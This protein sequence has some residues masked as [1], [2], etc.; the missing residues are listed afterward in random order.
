MRT[1][2]SRWRL[3]FLLLLAVGS[4]HAQTTFGFTGQVQTYTIPAAAGGIS[5]Q[6]SGAGGGGGGSDAS[7]NGFTGA[8][9]AGGKGASA[10]AT[11]IGPPGTVVKVYVG[12]GGGRGFTS[13]FGQSC[14]TSAGGGG[15]GSG[16]GGFAGGTG[17]PAGCSGYSG[18]GGGGGAAS[19]V[20]TA[21]DVALLVAGSGGGGQGGSWE[22][23]PNT[24]ANSS[25]QGLLANASV[26]S[27]GLAPNATD[28]GG[29]GG[30]GGGCAGGRGGDGHLDKSGNANSNPAGPG[31]SCPNTDLV[32]NFSVLAGGGGAGGA[33][34]PGDPSTAAN[35][36]QPGSN[37]SVVITPLY[38]TLG[39]VKSQPSPALAMGSNSVYTLTVSNSASVPANTARVLD[40]LPANLGYAG[41]SGTGWTCSSAANAAGTLVTC[42]FSGTI[43]P[44]GSTSLQVSVIPTNNLAVTNYASVD[45]A[46][47]TAPPN[48]ASCT[49]PNMPSAGCAA[50]VRSATATQ[51]G[52]SVYL[53]A[54]HNS[55]LDGGES[56]TG[57]ASLYVK[58]IPASGGTCTGPALTAA[59][60][61]AATG[62]YNLGN[63]AQGSYC[64]VLDANTN[65]SDITPAVPPGFIPTQN[66]S[67]VIRLV[68]GGAPP[69]PQNFGLYAGA[70]LSGSV[71]GDT[72]TGA[73]NANNGLQDGSE[74]GLAGV[75]VNALQGATAVASV[76]T[77][78]DGSF[79]LWLPT[80]SGTVSISPAAPSAFV[81]TGG[82]AGS[83]GGV[84]AR[85][86]VNS[87]TTVAGQSY[88]GLRFGLV[89]PNTLAPNGAQTAAAGTTVVYAHNFQAATAGQV[90]FSLASAANPASPAW[91]Q[92][93]YLDNNCNASLEPGEAPVTAPIS[94]SAG[95]VV[96]L[97]VKQQVPAGAP[98]GGQN[99]ASLT[100]AFNYTGAAPALSSALLAT[101]TTTVGQSGGLTLGKLVNNIT[102]GGAAA[103]SVTAKAGDALQ[104]TLTAINNGSQP[105]SA[106]VISDATPAYTTYLSAACPAT[107]PAGMTA[108]SVSS[109]P[110]VGAQGGL[111]WS[112]SGSLT[113]S[114]QLSVSYV[115]KVNQ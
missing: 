32:S 61:A 66:A 16:S 38:P 51:I 71:F 67:L 2:F 26:G 17:G 27:T 65:L 43:S 57:V 78:G 13:S 48:P 100:A 56:G 19:V 73:G 40:Q 35:G 22:S 89:P 58:L 106:V 29:G 50:P 55:N 34:A 76:M 85:P 113:P 115:V 15:S 80:G 39:L 84:Y 60:V 74:A 102:Q 45:P 92:V 28:G 64:L 7:G 110:A 23:A 109:Q 24:A 90:S 49:G 108:C 105:L 72:G 42:S 86:N 41:V 63:V 107:L 4:A 101:D 103:L 36:G 77:A 99:I 52:G 104:Y 18:G 54:N 68:V 11:F 59:P 14:T 31:G 97:I 75:T 111:Q 33:G 83:S 37:G 91:G 112:F 82:S 53:D 81:A 5:I 20:R 96:C 46:G 44:G 25:V 93:L 10:T 3:C 70:S 94:V 21:G 1:T 88:S 87:V 6:A 95:Q 62:A 30:G 12:G 79:T 47:G 114:A 98:T 69:A 9:G 8:G